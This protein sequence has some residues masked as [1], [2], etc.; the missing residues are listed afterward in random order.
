M[1]HKTIQI[2]EVYNLVRKGGN[3]CCHYPRLDNAFGE[4]KKFVELVKTHGYDVFTEKDVDFTYW[5]TEFNRVRELDA[6]K[7][8]CSFYEK[9]L[10]KELCV[11]GD[12]IFMDKDCVTESKEV[13]IK[14]ARGGQR[15]G[16]GRKAKH[17]NLIGASQT[18]VIR[19]PKFEKNKIKNLIDW[20]IEMEEEG[21]DVNFALFRS[22]SALEEKGD[23]E[24]A[25]LLE[26]L[27]SRLPYFSVR[28]VEK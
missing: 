3:Y 2:Q 15:E 24:N 8:G 26:E 27:R 20:L 5:Q 17:S 10:P 18:A 7:S 4:H 14:D 16:A 6:K 1:K 25:Q 9:Y 11:C 21:Q 22:E 12:W 28:K 19:V 23:K 13:E